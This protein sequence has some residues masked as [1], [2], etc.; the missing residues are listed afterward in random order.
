MNIKQRPGIKMAAHLFCL[1]SLTLT[2]GYDASFPEPR[3]DEATSDHQQGPSVH[4]KEE[5]GGFL[6]PGPVGQDHLF[7]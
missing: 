1:T 5:L 3:S 2:D 4:R 6:S 7:H